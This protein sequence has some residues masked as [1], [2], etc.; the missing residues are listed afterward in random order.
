MKII[1]TALLGIAAAGAY[2]QE[3]ENGSSNYQQQLEQQAAQEETETEDDSYWQYLEQRRKHPLNLNKCGEEELRELNMLTSLQVHHM[4]Q[5]R[6]LFGNFLSIYELQAVPGWDIN[7]IR[8][9][10]PFVTIQNDIEIPNNWRNWLRDGENRLL[11][12]FSQGLEKADGFISKHY[13]GSPLKMLARYKY[14]YRDQLQYGIMGDKDAGEQFFKGKQTFGFDFYSFHFFIRRIGMI[15]ALTLGDF[16]INLGQGLIH[17]QGQA[18]KK[19]SSVLSIKRQSHTLKPYTAAGEYNFHRGAAITLQHKGWQSTIFASLRKWSASIQQEDLG[20][21]YLN[22]VQTSGLHRSQTE[23]ANKHSVSA[24]AA[25]GNMQFRGGRGHIS[26]NTIFHNFSIPFQS[27]G[28]PYDF[29]ALSGKNWLNYSIDYSYTYANC[30][31]FGELAA[32]KNFNT[33][34]LH[35]LLASVDPK[36]DLGLVYRRISPAYQTVAANAFVENSQVVNENGLYAGLSLRPSYGWRIDAYA[37]F[38]RFPWLK[39]RVDAP[40]SG[41]DYLLQV[42]FTPSK[43]AELYTR[44]RFEA[45]EINQNGSDAPMP[46]LQKVMRTNWRSQISYQ[47]TKEINLQNRIEILWQ[48]LSNTSSIKSGFLFFQ[49]FQYTPG[50]QPWKATFRFQYFESDDYDTRLYAYENSVMY[51]FS[52]PAFFNK[53]IRYYIN[54]Q[55]KNLLKRKLKPI[56]CT[57]GINLSRSEYAAG[58]SVGSGY[59]QL[60]GS[61]KTEMRVQAIFSW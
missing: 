1:F 61:N 34:T 27:S 56:Q 17:W 40:S 30:H 28:D 23:L 11:F 53:G 35:G 12:R 37:D 60:P 42:I 6:A 7:T 3:N 46:A 15:K 57:F 25:G 59:D 55:Y 43:Q 41:S 5:Y 22:S 9:L 36:L 24:L 39:F 32:D 33:A 58:T 38:F 14:Q 29:Y 4:L 52:L 54:F 16:V 31:L 51:S 21:N 10:L 45:K 13:L 18:F 26:F 20:N 44:F 48:T 8:S 47:A 49:D 50:N 19:S 2:A